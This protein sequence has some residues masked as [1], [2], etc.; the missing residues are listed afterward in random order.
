MRQLALTVMVVMALVMNLMML[1]EVAMEIRGDERLLV[2]I[3]GL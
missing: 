1:M 3:V 2:V